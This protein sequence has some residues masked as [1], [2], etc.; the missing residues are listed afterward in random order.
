MSNLPDLK[1][2]CEQVLQASEHRGPP[3]DLEAICSLWTNLEVNEEDLDQ[4]GYLIPLGVLGATILIR[5]KDAPTRKK[6]TLAHELGHWILANVEAGQVC[7]GKTSA[8][9]LSFKSQHK[10]QTPQEVW[11]NQ[12]AACLLMPAR[13]VDD[14][15]GRH[16]KS[17][18]PER[19]SKGHM[20]FQVSQEAFLS[21]ISELKPLSVFEVVKATE[22]VRVR[23]SFI[24][25]CAREEPVKQVLERILEEFSMK[26]ELPAGPV[27]SDN[28]E[29]AA[30]LTRDSQYGRSWLVTV[31]P[32]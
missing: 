31:T 21:R 7:F 28:Y 15:F 11:C 14:Y 12:F 17:N 30:M 27:I 13:D 26:N 8:L 24:S 10:R 32:V 6:F 22:S 19:I 1:E 29:V 20:V 5:R 18:L 9:A 3:T 2:I 25:K 4:A 23:R 16:A